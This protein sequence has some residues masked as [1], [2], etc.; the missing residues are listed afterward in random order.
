MQL[1]LQSDLFRKPSVPEG[2]AYARDLISPADER[3]LIGEI[4]RLPLAK[5]RFQGFLAKRR[6]IYFGWRY[7]FD[8]SRFEPTEPI[9]DFLHDLR[10]RAARFAGLTP[11]E[12][13]HAL[14]TEYA[15]G[16]EIGWHRDRPVFERVFGLSLLSPCVLRFRRRRGAR[17]ERF[18]LHAPRR[19]AYLLS[20]EIRDQ[21]E[22]SI[23][24]LQAPRY[25]IT[26]RSRRR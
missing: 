10:A 26:F 14:V 24:P 23:A 2:F 3:A 8:R 18:P 15:P 9:P 17:F 20:G 5:F 7:D 12:L 25:S 21:W 4:A 6:V 11:D 19:S 1:E 16:V 13:P 22:H